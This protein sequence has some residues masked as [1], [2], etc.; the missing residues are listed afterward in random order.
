MLDRN[1]EVDTVLYLG[2]VSRIIVG[3]NASCFTE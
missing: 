3:V 1:F 2:I